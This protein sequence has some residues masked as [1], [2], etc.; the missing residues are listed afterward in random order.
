MVKFLLQHLPNELV[1]CLSEIMMPIIFTRLKEQWLD[2]AVPSSMEYMDEYQQSLAQ[3]NEFAATLGSLNW[4]AADDLYNWV[5]NA[6]KIWLSKRKE[7]ALDLTRNQ[8]ILGMVGSSALRHLMCNSY[9]VLVK[10]SEDHLGHTRIVFRIQYFAFL[11]T[12][13]FLGVGTP[14]IAHHF[15]KKTVAL[16]K[17]MDPAQTGSAEDRKSVV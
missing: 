16:D 4:P 15:E 2:P 17:D 12:L 7:T 1:K 6:H 3:V 11:L 5:S 13:I 14:T 8:L 9:I 10:S